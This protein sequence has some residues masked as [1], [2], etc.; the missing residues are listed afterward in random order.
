MPMYNVAES[1]DSPTVYAT[2]TDDSE[3]TGSLL[4]ETFEGWLDGPGREYLKIDATSKEG[5]RKLAEEND[6]HLENDYWNQN[7]EQTYLD[8]FWKVQMKGVKDGWSCSAEEGMH[9]YTSTLTYY[10]CGL[11]HKETGYLTLESIKES[12]FTSL[13]IGTQSEISGQDF[14]DAWIKEVFYTKTNAKH[15]QLIPLKVRFI[16]RANL[17]AGQL[18]W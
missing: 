10:L 2:L 1:K 7:I 15:L 13:G 6:I 5:Q 18:S 4:T 17:D 3:A 9:R 16:H 14:R 12:D 11:P 8:L